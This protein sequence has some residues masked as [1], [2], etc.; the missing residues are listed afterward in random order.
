MWMHK[1]R[2]RTRARSR[3]TQKETVQES[4]WRS[5]AVDDRSY[6]HFIRYNWRKRDPFLIGRHTRVIIDK[7]EEALSNYERGISTYLTITVPYRH[8]KTD[9][10]G[11][12]LPPFALGHFPDLEIMYTTY[13]DTL[14]EQISRDALSIMRGQRYQRCF[15]DV[16]L[17]KRSA[18][19][20]E[21][22]I[23]DEMDEPYV[24]KCMALG[25]QGGATGKGAGMLVIDDAIK[26][27]EVAESQV[28][29]DKCWDG[30]EDNLMTRLAPV[31]IVIVMMTR[32]HVDDPIGRIKK[33]EEEPDYPIHWDHIHFKAR[34]EQPDGSYH[35][36]FLERFPESWY[37]NQFARNAYSAAALLQGEPVAK[38]GNLFAVDEIQIVDE[39]PTGL[40]QARGWDLASSIKER[41]TDDPDYTCGIKGAYAEEATD[42]D[43][44]AVLLPWLYVED[45]KYG[46][47]EAPER[48]QEIRQTAGSD[49][50]GC[51]VGVETVAGYK[52]TGTRLKAALQG[53]ALVRVQNVH[54]DKV[55]RAEELE[56]IVK[57]GR[58]LMKRA[59]WNTWLLEQLRQFPLGKH[60]DGVDALHTMYTTSKARYDRT[61]G[62]GTS[63]ATGKGAFGA[64]C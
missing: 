32:W 50:P 37:I 20:K 51:W 54:H 29:R 47:W 49:G 31:H 3:R 22:S 11:R 2:R 38:G 57:A 12:Y 23:V 6:E 17:N 39:I 28:Q 46:Q 53:R 16:R 48:D 44:E 25:V 13:G 34:E 1:P 30:I 40:K 14:S 26:S 52:D 58:L 60:D 21:W 8:G 4:V 35:Y 24:G 56:P 10:I 15:P 59:S 62:F 33:R 55:F 61:R 19:V 45:C 5:L 36:L 63:A 7:V 9:V 43:G 27:R 42:I 64:K 41:D 18:S